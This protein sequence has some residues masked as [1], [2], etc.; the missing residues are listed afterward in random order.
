MPCS[1]SVRSADAGF[2]TA[3]DLRAA[4]DLSIQVVSRVE[5]LGRNPDPPPPPPPPPVPAEEDPR[6]PS[7]VFTVAVV[8]VNEVQTDAQG[9]TTVPLRERAERGSETLRM[10][11][12]R[13]GR[14]R[15]QLGAVI[16]VLA[17]E[18]LR[19]MS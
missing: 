13:R 6:R 18:L 1:K 7:R 8:A 17:V 19:C 4:Y 5:A 14:H 10:A 2:S 16:H 11:A 9:T 15:P 12:G 3:V